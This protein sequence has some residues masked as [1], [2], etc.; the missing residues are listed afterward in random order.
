MKKLHKQSADILVLTALI[1]AV[2]TLFAACQHMSMPVTQKV[3]QANSCIRLETL[4]QDSPTRSHETYRCVTQEFMRNICLLPSNDMGYVTQYP[5]RCTNN[6]K[7]ASLLAI[8][9]AHYADQCSYTSKV[10]CL[11]PPCVS[12]TSYPIPCQSPYLAMLPK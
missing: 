6:G 7:R 11:P 1:V 8:T 3:A 2:C 10:P 9:Q 4:I 5:I 12:Y